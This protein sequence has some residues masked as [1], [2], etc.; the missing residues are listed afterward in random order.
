MV[1]WTFVFSSRRRHTRCALVTGV[2]T[3]ALPIS[4]NAALGGAWIPALVFGIPG[5]S[6]T[7]IAIGVMFM[8]GLTPGPMI[9]LNN[10][11]MLYGVFVAFIMA[12]ILMLP[13][14][15]A[16]IKG[17]SRLLSVP[18]PVLMPIILL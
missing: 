7:A 1:V 14:G 11:E 6:I 2:Q 5:D 18:R 12:N 10:P 17:A 13:F 4:N 3:C 15:W 8:K 9:F 16:A